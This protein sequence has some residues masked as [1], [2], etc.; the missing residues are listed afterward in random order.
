MLTLTEAWHPYWAWEHLYFGFF[1]GD[2]LGMGA[3]ECEQKRKD[4][5]VRD[6]VFIETA[7]VVSTK[8]PVCMEHFLT[9][10]KVN[11]VAF[12][13]QVCSFYYSGVG[14]KFSYAYNQLPRQ[15]KAENNKLAQDFIK[16]WSFSREQRDNRIH[17]TVE[18]ER[19]RK[20][21]TPGVPR[22]LESGGVGSFIQ[23]DMFSHTAK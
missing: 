1:D 10:G 5:F 7:L 9:P 6:G 12:L 14:A 20:G 16:Q 21:F 19:L 4:F 22:F 23:G 18:E 2:P 3:R 17:K 15:V 11:P 8:W 13:G